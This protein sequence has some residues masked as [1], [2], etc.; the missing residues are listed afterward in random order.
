MTPFK[1]SMC[2]AELGVSPEQ[3]ADGIVPLPYC[4]GYLEPLTPVVQS[5]WKPDAEELKAINE[6]HPILLQVVGRT[7]PPLLVAVSAIKE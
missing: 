1:H 3:A 5:F 2:N 4:R 6:G 7:H